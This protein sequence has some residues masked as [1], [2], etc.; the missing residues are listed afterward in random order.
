MTLADKGGGGIQNPPFLTDV[1]CEQPLSLC[2]KVVVMI[3]PPYSTIG[4]PQLSDKE[5]TKT[6][7]EL[8][9]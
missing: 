6:K 2:Y 9:T 8:R 4:A 3:K 1:M 7:K 5:I